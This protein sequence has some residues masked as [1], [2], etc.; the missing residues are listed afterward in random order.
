MSAGRLP[1]ARSLFWPPGHHAGRWRTLPTVQSFPGA[2]PTNDPCDAE[3]NAPRL[4]LKEI[5]TH[6]QDTHHRFPARCKGLGKADERILLRLLTDTLQCPA[7]LKNF[8]SSVSGICQYCVE[9]ADTY[10][11]LWPCQ[12]NPSLPP[13]PQPNPRGRGGG[14]ARLPKPVGPTS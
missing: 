10:H 5:T 2:S 7:A 14:S 8:D 1:L 3:D 11:M 13:A 12:P 4:T 6:Y 9:V